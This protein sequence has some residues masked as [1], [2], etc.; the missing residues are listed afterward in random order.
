MLL[1][2]PVENTIFIVV[3][4]KMEDY[5]MEYMT[6][7]EAAKL[8]LISKRRVITLCNS[9]RILGAV[10]VGKIWLIPKNANKPEDGRHTRYTK[11][12]A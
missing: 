10:M 2:F 1:M 6:T 3:Y 12:N 4:A 8:W 5:V 7:M 11:K 9:K